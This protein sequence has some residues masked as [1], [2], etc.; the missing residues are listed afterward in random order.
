[1]CAADSQASRENKWATDWTGLTGETVGIDNL[2]SPVDKTDAL[3][4]TGMQISRRLQLQ[5]FSPPPFA[6]LYHDL[7][8]AGWL[9]A[10]A[11][12]EPVK[13]KQYNVL[14]LYQTGRSRTES[15]GVKPEPDHVL[16]HLSVRKIVKKIWI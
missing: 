1:M 15:G 2:H 5:R 4:G 13:P 6:T 16:V 14:C 11:D 10:V 8:S 3:S 7:A 9:S 12:R